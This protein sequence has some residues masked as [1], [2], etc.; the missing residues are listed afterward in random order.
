MARK[1]ALLLII[2]LVFVSSLLTGCGSP[3]EDATFLGYKVRPTDENATGIAIVQLA[4]GR[5]AEAECTYM[6]LERG[7]PIQVERS[8]DV[9][10]VVQASPDWNPR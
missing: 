4:D 6:T 1:R 5:P 3:A 8:G 2:G 10:K 7:T 9:Y